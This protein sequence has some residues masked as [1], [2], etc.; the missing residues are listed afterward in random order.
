[1]FKFVSAVLALLCVSAPGLR[2]ED[3]APVNPPGV[4]PAP[5][6]DWPI[7]EDGKDVDWPTLRAVPRVP[8][9]ST[10]LKG[11]GTTDRRIG[12]WVQGL[13]I[14]KEKKAKVELTIMRRKLQEESDAFLSEER[15]R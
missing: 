11:N 8:A 2:A 5:S 13:I 14:A 1:M 10:I 9:Q 3:P 4:T 15:D 6:L 7:L 12:V